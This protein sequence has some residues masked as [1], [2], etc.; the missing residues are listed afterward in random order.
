[1][2]T[3]KIPRMKKLLLGCA[4][5]ALLMTTNMAAAA[6]AVADS[7]EFEPS[8]TVKT[9]PMYIA[10]YNEEVAEEHGFKIVTDKDGNEHSV[11]VTE[12]AKEIVAAQDEPANED[13]IELQNIVYGDCGSSSVFIAKSSPTEISIATSYSVYTTSISHQWEVGGSSP[14]GVWSEGFSGL[15]SGSSWSAVH[16]AYVGDSS[17]VFAGVTEGSF[18]QLIDGAVCY[19]G[20]PSD[21]I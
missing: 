12:E 11:P 14:D 8:T 15:N 1:M 17:D 13:G 10:G 6:P 9:T 4:S 2:G 5:A 18:A 19:S 7:L 21:R 20:G 16:E 3:N